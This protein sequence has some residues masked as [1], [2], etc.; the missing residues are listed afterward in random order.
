MSTWFCFKTVHKGL[1][2]KWNVCHV[3]QPDVFMQFYTM[4][5]SICDIKR[6]FAVKHFEL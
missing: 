2:L 6:H 4:A 5:H 1:F 3:E